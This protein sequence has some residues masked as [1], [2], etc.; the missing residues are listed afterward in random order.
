MFSLSSLPSLSR[1]ACR[2][3]ASLFSCRVSSRALG[4][5]VAVAGFRGSASASAFSRLCA[6][7]LPALCGGCVV[8]FVGGLFLVSVP[9]LP[10]SVPFL[11]RAGAGP[12][13]CVGAPPA[14]R[15]SFLAGG[16]WSVWG[17]AFPAP[18]G[19]G[20]AFPAPFSVPAGLVRACA[21]AGAVAF[22]GSRRVAP[23]S[24]LLGLFPALVPPAVPVFVGCVGGLCAAVRGLFPLARVFRAASFGAGAGAF[25]AR[26]CALVRACAGAG[27]VWLSFPACACPV[28][29]VPSSSSSACFCGSGSGSW[30]S[31]CFAVGLGVPAF[32]WLPASVPAPAWLSPLGGGWWSRPAAQ[33]RLF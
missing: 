21:G 29:L 13:C 22:C 19:R 28:G 2:L 20:A 10:A 26:S 14:V 7:S 3:G 8:R 12:V 31:L 9:V 6:A 4:G 32:V 11:V 18:P 27:G 17:P 16:V 5:F 33:L 15:A 25:A 1:S 23:P 30:A 24:G